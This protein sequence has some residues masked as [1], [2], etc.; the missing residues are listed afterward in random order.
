MDLEDEFLLLL[1]LVEISAALG[2]QYQFY[3]TLLEDHVLEQRRLNRSLPVNKQRPTW[4]QFLIHTTD[5]K[6]RQMFRMTHVVFHSLCEQIV[7][8]IGE[9]KFKPE[10]YLNAQG[11]RLPMAS[12]HENVGGFIPF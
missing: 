9:K 3:C 10:T 11:Y 6:F 8:V 5:R 12:A 4:C 2:L 7:N 1:L